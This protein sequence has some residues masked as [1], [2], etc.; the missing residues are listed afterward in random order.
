MKESE[1]ACRLS[2]RRVHDN[3]VKLV[4]KLVCQML[5]MPKR[6][7]SFQGASTAAVMVMVGLRG[8]VDSQATSC[9]VGFMETR[10][11]PSVTLIS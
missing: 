1:L 11:L 6:Q 3:I 5:P 4:F 10:I 8:S 2:R 9:C 7:T